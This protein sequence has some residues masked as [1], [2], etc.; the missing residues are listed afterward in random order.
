MHDTQEGQAQTSPPLTYVHVCPCVSVCWDRLEVQEVLSDVRVPWGSK[1][2]R[3]VESF[4]HE[5]RDTLL[6]LAPKVQPPPSH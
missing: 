3:G 1:R 4:L 5:L 6:G 2:V